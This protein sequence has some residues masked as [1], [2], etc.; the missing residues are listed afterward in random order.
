MVYH[1]INRQWYLVVPK[2]WVEAFW[3]L[4][5]EHLLVLKGAV[6]LN[7]LYSRGRNLGL[8]RWS[9]S[10]W[11]LDDPPREKV[12]PQHV[13]V[14][15]HFV[16]STTH[17]LHP[18]SFFFLPRWHVSFLPEGFRNLWTVLKNC[19]FCSSMSV[20]AASS[21]IVLTSSP[22]PSAWHGMV[23]LARFAELSLYILLNAKLLV[24]LVRSP[25]VIVSLFSSYGNKCLQ[26]R[27]ALWNIYLAKMPN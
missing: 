15:G 23:N 7:C 27:F 22:L 2:K 10:M 18:S 21:A 17:F 5:F 1:N 19:S 12:F 9:F 24:R 14:R 16:S 3:S 20:F 11:Y 13:T 6:F 8:F 26:F 4:T 25:L